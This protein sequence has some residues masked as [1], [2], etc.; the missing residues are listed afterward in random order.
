MSAKPQVVIYWLI[1]S[2]KYEMNRHHH[3]HTLTTCPGTAF[4]RVGFPTYLHHSI[5]CNFFNTAFL[6]KM[7]ASIIDELRC[8]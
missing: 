8:A 5:V 6:V 2:G 3:Y 7:C 1:L 4:H